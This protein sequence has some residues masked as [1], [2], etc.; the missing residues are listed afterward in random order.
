M[1][2]WCGKGRFFWA[3]IYL[4]IG[5]SVLVGVFKGRLNKILGGVESMAMVKPGLGYFQEWGSHRNLFQGLPTLTRNDFFHVSDLNVP[6]CHLKP[7][8]LVLRT[9]IFQSVGVAQSP[10]VLLC[11]CEEWQGQCRWDS[12][13]LGL[14]PFPW[15]WVNKPSQGKGRRHF[16]GEL[17]K[18]LL[19]HIPLTP[20]ALNQ[21]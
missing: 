14:D 5:V 7:F 10:E 8:P 16:T 18:R 21:A 11:V 4:Q 17:S 6:F 3:W 15:I 9:V 12:L 1:V 20:L 19:C 13:K 2:T